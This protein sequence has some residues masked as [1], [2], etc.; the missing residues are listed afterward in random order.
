MRKI[1]AILIDDE[2]GA[3]EVL[4]NLLS[5]FCTDVEVVAEANNLLTGI[6]Q[7]KEFNPDVVFLDI[8]MPKYSGYEIVNFIDKI[9]FSIVFITAYDKYALKAFEISALDYILKPIEVDRLKSAVK[10]VSDKQVVK[11]AQ[12]QY[13][14]LNDTITKHK[15]TKITITDKGENLF[16]NIEDIIAVEGQ[17]AY[18]KM[19]LT[20]DRQYILSRNLKQ[21]AVLLDDWGCFFRSHKSWLINTKC[22]RSYSKSKSEITLSQ[23]IIAK[24]SRYKKAEF[25]EVNAVYF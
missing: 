8:Q 19:Y 15:T 18:C 21:T 3:R 16:V 20:D 11:V 1:K 22:V 24:L 4:N 25:E 9:D 13:T 6:E 12:E 7:I 17:S 5:R 10:K 23:N 2:A 14:L